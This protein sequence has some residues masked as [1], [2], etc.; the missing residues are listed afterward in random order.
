M[1]VHARTPLQLVGSMRWHWLRDGKACAPMADGVRSIMS[2]LPFERS[3]VR[4][5]GRISSGVRHGRLPE[6]PSLPGN[7]G[8]TASL[9]PSFANSLRPS[10]RSLMKASQSS[11]V[12]N[13]KPTELG[14]RQSSARAGYVVEFGEL[15]LVL[16][17][18]ASGKRC[19]IGVIHQEKRCAPYC[20]GT[21]TKLRMPT[22]VLLHQSPAGPAPMMAT[23]AFIAV[24]VSERVVTRARLNGHPSQIGEGIDPGF[25]AEV[26]DATAL[27]PPNGICASSCTVGPFTWQMPDSMRPATWM[28]RATSRPKTAAARPYS[29]SLAQATALPRHAHARCLSRGRKPPRGRCACPA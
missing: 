10:R 6:L 15:H 7:C 3:G 27:T 21:V 8:K 28:A 23:C 26:P 11:S 14:Q 12:S 22:T 16:E 9:T 18:S 20:I 13:G 24:S 4:A 29:L 17:P 19:S 2:C 5:P 1:G 25:P